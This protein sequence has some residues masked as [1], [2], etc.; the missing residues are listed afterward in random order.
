[1]DN[2]RCS[3]KVSVSISRDL[4]EKQ[5]FR[6]SGLPDQI[7]GAMPPYFLSRKIALLLLFTF[8]SCLSYSQNLLTCDPGFENAAY[9]ACW[10]WHRWTGA[11][12]IA[13]ETAIVQ[14]GTRSIK[15][16]VTTAPTNFWEIGLTSQSWSK[17]NGQKYNVTFY[18]RSAVNGTGIVVRQEGTSQ[19]V[20]NN[21]SLTTT[22]TAYTVVFT[23]TATENS[24][25]VFYFPNTG[26]IYLDNI[27]ITAVVSNC[28][29]SLFNTVVNPATQYQ[30]VQG[31]GGAIAYYEQW[32]TALPAASKEAIY[33]LLFRGL[34]LDW[35]RLKN[36]GGTSGDT[37]YTV[38]L[39]KKARFY[40]SDSLRLL[41]CSWSPPVN[42]KSN[43]A[44]Q[45]G[46]LKKVAGKFNYAGFADWWRQSL[47]NYSALGVNPDMISFQNEPDYDVTDWSCRFDAAEGTN[48]GYDTALD[49]VYN[50][51]KTL[52]RVPKMIGAEPLGIGYGTFDAYSTPIKNK[53]HLYGYAYH[54]YH[55]GDGADPDSYISSLNNI[56]NN[57]GNRPNI[58]TEYEKFDAG[59][60][61][62]AWLIN[63]V[64]TEANAEVYFYWDLMWPRCCGN[65]L[66][67]IENPWDNP[68]TWT[69]SSG[70]KINPHYYALKH[71][72]R[73]IEAG[74]TRISSVTDN[75]EL[76]TSAY[77]N[78]AGNSITIELI[79][80]CSS[81]VTTTIAV[82]GYSINSSY[83]IQSADP[84]YDQ[85]IGSLPANNQVLL[86][87]QSV[88]TIVL[89]I[90]NPLP[91]DMASFTGNKAG[92]DVQLYWLT[93]GK[94][95][96]D[97]FIVERSAEELHFEKIDS[98]EGM[99]KNAPNI[100][101]YSY[102]DKDV[103]SGNLYYRLK[104]PGLDGTWTYSNII[105]ISDA[106]ESSVEVSP[107]PFPEFLNVKVDSD[108]SYKL[109]DITG[110]ILESGTLKD[111]P[112]IGLNLAD[113]IYLLT[114]YERDKV[115]V[116]RVMKAGN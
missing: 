32:L 82:T 110:R 66:I 83:I 41:M 104:M 75:A 96:H 109:L 49:S 63:T 51:I 92:R 40:R 113:G 52:S 42:L 99:N 58:M 90:A 67:N 97:Y 70:Y 8:I 87:G 80:T 94:D 36:Y 76:R 85:N 65:G 35:L 95:N 26:T 61:K 112:K 13:S 33:Q 43:N 45:A 50:K 14:E 46:T 7:R 15:I 91:V 11:A 17:V 24:R 29:S 81:S 27:Q 68:S 6:S 108:C 115:V 20:D 102:A 71:F 3:R 18:A 48:A 55:G 78:A 31:F 111:D 107:N 34:G 89:S 84:S 1:M 98:V 105:F 59:W 106:A 25:L 53:A 103:P 100:S 72:S 38:E 10:T 57:Y 62:T 73:Y 60:L 86:P 54:L 28:T 101:S 23:A 114:V 12:T 44:Y 37:V 39:V 56:R 93:A 116:R 88:T 74:Y 19:T 5:M 16:N 77:M 21:F 69:Y 2:S 47:L 4:A 9:S 22:W 64:M 30:T 79:N